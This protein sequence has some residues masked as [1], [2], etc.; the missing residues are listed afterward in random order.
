M[1]TAA[2]ARAAAARFAARTAPTR[3]RAAALCAALA[4]PLALAGAPAAAAD[5][6]PGTAPDAIPDTA[7]ETHT[8]PQGGESD[9][10]TNDVN[11]LLDQRGVLHVEETLAFGGGGAAEFTR[12][13]LAREPYD[14]DHDRL[15]RV[16]GISAQAAGGA[17]VP[18]RTE[19][20]DGMVDLVLERG[21]A[22]TVVL[23]YTVTGAME[24]TAD[25]VEL[26]WSPI[27]GYSERVAETTVR[28][29]APQPPRALS[30]SA[31]VPRSSIYC[32]SSDM[33][34]HEGL[35]ARFLQADMAPGERLSI[36]V[37]YPEGTASADPVLD[38]T[39]SLTSAFAITPKTA[40]VFGLLLLGLIGGLIAL[41]RLRGQDERALRTESGAASNAPLEAGPD[42]GLRFR[43]PDGVH[44]GQ[45]GT[46]IDG[47]ADV[48]DIAG[49]VVDLAVR[50]H[51][52]IEELPHE[53]GASVDW[54]LSKR[55]PPADEELLP[56]ERML[57]DALFDRRVRVRL[58]QL[59]RG[60]FAQRLGGVRDELYRDMVRLRWFA[61][62]PNVERNG[63]ASAG[64][65]LTV[66]G[67]LLTVLLAAFTQA[68]F[69][70]LAVVIAG[71]ALTVGAQYM[72][73]RTAKG[74][75]VLAHTLGFRAFLMSAEAEHVPE[76]R[77]VDLFSRYL[78]YA[79]IFDNVDRWAT[80]LA[81]A[82][83]TE[84]TANNRLPWYEGP[85][86]WQVEDFAESIRAFVLTLAGVI[87]SARQLR[88]LG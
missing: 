81:A 70:G 5:Q 13:L 35:V 54:M 8:V 14:A 78:P 58:S 21:E 34:G 9:G 86:E 88:A 15:Y 6:G 2:T 64:I 59:R 12:T 60:G 52:T 77:R 30:C 1:R 17:G 27:A 71:A 55:V 73:A 72:P 40:S 39:W 49:T 69:T 68:A 56:Y 65:G 85:D 29:D 32:T 66:G 25:G 4:A 11:V 50:G 7:P 51:F 84:E 83:A 28:V 45:I 18:V 62:R 74:S 48:V 44:P 20:Y 47:Q 63:W 22:E 23:D 10:I 3:V 37:A 61:N 53:S 82:G 57:I 19:E 41:I 36:V 43:P 46:L 67:V 24:Q 87:S 31:G 80:V 16:S 26:E 42:D 38:R 33:G 75:S 76:G 79:I